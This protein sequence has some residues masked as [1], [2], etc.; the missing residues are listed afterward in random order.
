MNWHEAMITLKTVHLYNL[1][2]NSNAFHTSNASSLIYLH[3]SSLSFQF[4]TSSMIPPTKCSF[5]FPST[6]ACQTRIVAACM[7]TTDFACS[8]QYQAHHAWYSL[9]HHITETLPASNSLSQ[10][11]LLTNRPGKSVKPCLLNNF[12]SLTSQSQNI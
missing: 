3:R 4:R 9:L 1:F 12:T 8:W 10:V 6:Q 7:T 5:S 2:I 11:S